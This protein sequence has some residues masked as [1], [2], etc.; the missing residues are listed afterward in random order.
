MLAPLRSVN[1]QKFSWLRNVFLKYFQD[2]LNS[3]QQSEGQGNFTRWWANYKNQ[4]KSNQSLMVV[5]LIVVWLPEL[6]SHFHVDNL[7]KWKIK[8]KYWIKKVI[9]SCF[10][11]NIR[12]HML[13]DYLMYLCYFFSY[14]YKYFNRYWENQLDIFINTSTKTAIFIATH[15]KKHMAYHY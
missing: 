4:N 12:K 9:N 3:V 11:K 8:C 10:S 6:T 2:W 15:L 5:L 14:L 13:I 1:D 7:K